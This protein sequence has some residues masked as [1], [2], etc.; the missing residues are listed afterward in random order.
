M[1]WKEEV[2][3]RDSATRAT[4]G[5]EGVLGSAFGEGDRQGHHSPGA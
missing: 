2:T 4:G 3:D 1:V 5:H